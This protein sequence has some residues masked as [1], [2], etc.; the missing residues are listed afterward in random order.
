MT[1]SEMKCTMT[2]APSASPPL[3]RHAMAYVLAGGRGSRL[4]EMTDRRAK[5]GLREEIGKVEEDRDLFGDE[6]IAMPQCRH[7]SHRV[8]CEIFGPAL[9]SGLHVEHVQVVGN[10]ELFE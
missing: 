6:S 3:A 7:L 9:F 4:M 2:P 5:P 1:L 8:D 10:A